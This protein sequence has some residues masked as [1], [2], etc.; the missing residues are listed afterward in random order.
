[1]HR[2]GG[3]LGRDARA[4]ALGVDDGDGLDR[5]GAGREAGPEA[6]HPRAVGAHDAAPAHHH[7][8]PAPGASGPAHGA[9]IGRA[10]RSRAQAWPVFARMNFDRESSERNSSVRSRPSSITMPK[11]SSRATDS[12]MKSS[13]SR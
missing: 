8:W 11:R 1:G 10:A 9:S 6:L 13:E 7:V 2:V 3:D 12:S 4:E 5:A